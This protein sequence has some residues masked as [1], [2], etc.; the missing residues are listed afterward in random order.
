MSIVLIIRHCRRGMQH[1]GQ[2]ASDAR[3]G[4][5]LLVEWQ[6]ERRPQC[7][8]PLPC[9]IRLPPTGSTLTA[10]AAGA[11]PGSREHD[12]E[13]VPV[14][15][16]DVHKSFGSVEAVRGVDLTIRSRGGPGVP[17]PQWCGEDVDDR[18]GLGSF[19]A[20]LWRGRGLRHAPRRAITKGLVSAV[21]QSGGL[22][23]DFTV[24]ETVL[25][26]S[27]LFAASRPVSE[28]LERA[29]IAGIADRLVGKC[30]GGEQ[31]RLRFAMALLPDP[32]LLLP[33]EPTQGMDVEGAAISGRRFA[34]TPRGAARSSS[35]RTISKRPTPTPT[36]SCSSAKGGS[37]PTER[38]PRSRP[39]RRGGLSG[40]PCPVPTR[41]RYVPCRASTTSRSAGI[42][43]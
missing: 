1:R 17:W 38:Q 33:D 30:S 3:R 41:R 13:T 16:R 35:P 21:M 5:I 22:L 20:Q 27:K 4:L 2:G 39:S 36:A 37:S 8:V 10:S 18:P 24:Q 32:E 6:R 40:R 29:S 12:S 26:T 43:S 23:K 19:A 14:L 31:Q 15:L 7:L 34:M 42:A 9:R 25:Y 11:L 28:V